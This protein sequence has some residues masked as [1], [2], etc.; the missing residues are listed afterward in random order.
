MWSPSESLKGVTPWERVQF[1]N[2]T[3]KNFT[4]IRDS[5][6][7]FILGCVGMRKKNRN[8][9]NTWRSTHCFLI[10]D[11]ENRKLTADRE[12]GSQ[13]ELAPRGCYPLC[14]GTAHSLC[15]G[16]TLSL[17]RGTAHTLCTGHSTLS[18]YR[19]IA[20]SLCTGH[21]TLSLYRVQHTLFV[22]GHS[23]LSLCRG[24]AHSL[25]AG[26]STLSLCRGTAH[27]L[28]TGHSTLSLYRGTAHSLYT[29]HS[30]LSILPHLLTLA[31]LCLSQALSTRTPLMPLPLAASI[32]T[33][34]P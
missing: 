15:T 23:T 12:I 16:H 25:C 28:C 4:R 32:F 8:V 2:P 33:A 14:R 22:P 24:T 27:S 18:L 21:S 3:F 20:H 26:H 29:G 34:P 13:A 6:C 30:T 1:L 11:R 31:H 17:Y 7:F 19:G 9:E 5:M 10:S